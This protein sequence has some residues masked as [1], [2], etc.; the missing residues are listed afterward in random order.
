M[1][2]ICHVNLYFSC[3]LGT[4]QPPCAVTLPFWFCYNSHWCIGYIKLFCLFLRLN[5]AYF[6]TLYTVFTMNPA[7]HLTT[8]FSPIAHSPQSTA[9]PQSATSQL[10]LYLVCPDCEAEDVAEGDPDLLPYPLDHRIRI[11]LNHLHLPVVIAIHQHV[12]EPGRQVSGGLIDSL[13]II[14]QRDG[15]ST[16]S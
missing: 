5:F 12:R 6:T 7:S 16:T 13:R 14:N 1:T 9:N 3:H 8:I 2:R 10:L 11:R 15:Y 4:Q